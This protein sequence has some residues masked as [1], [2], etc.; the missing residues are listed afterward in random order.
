MRRAREGDQTP[1]PTGR[2]AYQ[3]S[4]ILFQNEQNAGGR[5]LA[6]QR[7]EILNFQRFNTETEFLGNAIRPTVAKDQPVRLSFS[8]KINR[9][10]CVLPAKFNNMLTIF[11]Q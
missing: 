3:T 4:N 2:L 10:S 8:P 7:R 5:T 9:H 1:L 11:V 6:N